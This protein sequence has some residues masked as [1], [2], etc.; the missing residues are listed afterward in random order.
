M[1]DRIACCA[2]RR[3][4]TVKRMLAI[5]TVVTYDRNVGYRHYEA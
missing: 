3:G 1:K 4:T 5:A 2:L